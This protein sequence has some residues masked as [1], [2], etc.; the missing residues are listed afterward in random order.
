MIHKIETANNLIAFRALGQVTTADFKSVVLP[1]IEGLSKQSNGINFLFAVDTD[2]QN[3][4][5]NSW[6]QDA[7]TGLKQFENWNRVAIVSDSEEASFGDGFTFNTTGEFR[8]FKKLAFNKALK[9][10]EGNQNI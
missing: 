5:E 1:E 10:V 6:L 8:G 9:W 3:F 2:I 4:T 7:V